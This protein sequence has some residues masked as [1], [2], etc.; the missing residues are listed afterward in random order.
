ML[1]A[2][3]YCGRIH[4]STYDCGK[5]PERKW[6]E[7]KGEDPRHTHAWHRKARQIK[8]DA[9]FR[10]ELC[11]ARGEVQTHGLEAHHITPI[12]EDESLLLDD[13]NIICLCRYCHEAAEAG[14]IEREM[15]KSIV[16]RRIQIPPGANSV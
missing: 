14:K 7:N 1:K 16:S 8:E 2:C 11:A 13:D 15:L 12:R 9:G 4:D 6:E 5:K 10:C 3:A